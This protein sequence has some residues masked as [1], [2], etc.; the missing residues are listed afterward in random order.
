MKITT[1]A[2]TIECTIDE[3]EELVVRGLIPGKEELIE[4]NKEDDWIGMLQKLVPEKPKDAKPGQ[5]WPP[6]VALYGCEMLSPI[7]A[8]GCP[9][10]PDNKL[11]DKPFST[12]TFVTDDKSNSIDNNSKLT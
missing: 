2:G 11:Y 10:V 5:N 3:Y 6:T 1:P 7:T 4:K 9:S 12:T 8:Y